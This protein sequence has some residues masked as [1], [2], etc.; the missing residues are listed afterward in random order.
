MIIKYTYRNIITL[1]RGLFDEYPKWKIGA[2]T[3]SFLLTT[4]TKHQQKIRVSSVIRFLFLNGKTCEE[5]KHIH[6]GVHETHSLFPATVYRWFAKLR[7]CR[8]SVFDKPTPGG[9]KN[10]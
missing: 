9:P 8:I 5:V 6:N 1:I 10:G 4:F 3:H 2:A 7:R